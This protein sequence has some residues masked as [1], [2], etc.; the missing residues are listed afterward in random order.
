MQNPTTASLWPGTRRASSSTPDFMLATNSSGGILLS[1]AVAAAGSV[2]APV[3]PWPDNRSMASAEYPMPAKRPATERTQSL[4]PLFSWITKTPPRGCGAA[5][6]APWSWP[7]GPAQVTGAV[8]NAV[9]E[10]GGG[11]A[12]LGGD[13]VGLAV[14][15]VGL[16]VGDSDVGG[17]ACFCS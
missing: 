2:K 7:D 10:P 6:Q 8:G 14:V 3:P 5:A 11:P 12:G 4:S 13:P 9:A 16:G 17:A 1:A 15:P